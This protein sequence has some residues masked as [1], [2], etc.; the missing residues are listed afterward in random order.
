VFA[1]AESVFDKGNGRAPQE[2]IVALLSNPAVQAEGELREV[3]PVADPATRTFQVKVTLKNPP[4]QM[5]FG[6]SVSGRVK[7]S[8]APVVM[9]PAAALFDKSGAPAVWVVDRDRNSISLKTVLVDRYETD[10]VIVRGG[11]HQG[12]IVVTAGVNRLRENQTVR[13]AEGVTR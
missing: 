3:S 12:D 11:L 10:R 1:I 5:R 2:I 8:T 9:L 6:A 7:A 13:V 4:E